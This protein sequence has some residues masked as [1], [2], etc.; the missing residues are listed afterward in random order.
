M[1]Y[2]SLQKKES[3]VLTQL[4]SDEPWKHYVQWKK[5]DTKGQI[6]HETSKTGQSTQTESRLVIVRGVSPL[7]RNH[8]LLENV[9]AGTK[10]QCGTNMLMGFPGVSVVKNPLAG[11]TGSIP[12]LGRSPGEGN[13]SP[14]QYSCLGNSMDRGAWWAQSMG[15]QKGWTWF[16]DWTI[17]STFQTTEEGTC[18]SI[19]LQHGDLVTLITSLL[20]K[21]LG[22]LQ[23]LSEQSG[24]NPAQ[25][26][27]HLTPKQPLWCSSSGC[28]THR[29][30]PPFLAFAALSC[31]LKGPALPG[32]SACSLFCIWEHNALR[33][34]PSAQACKWDSSL[35]VGCE[36]RK[37]RDGIWVSALGYTRGPWPTNVS[38]K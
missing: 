17:C 35:L 33:Y 31:V 13:G 34:L 10:L 21:T 2:Y 5:P 12:G 25:T 7:G 30:S 37:G 20:L 27:S 19:S 8:G 32:P 18:L 14:L 16:S 23:S 36:P 15:S 28:L 3:E 22:C 9:G 6:S 29:G 26:T 11:D 1:E 4:H 38:S 24:G